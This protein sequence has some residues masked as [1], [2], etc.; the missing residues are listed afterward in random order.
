MNE[1]TFV[2][3]IVAGA[4]AIAFGFPMAQFISWAA[5]AFARLVFGLACMALY[6][7]GRLFIAVRD[8]LHGEY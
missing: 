6:W 5:V 8:S 2:Y 7:T 4:F 1:S 3:W